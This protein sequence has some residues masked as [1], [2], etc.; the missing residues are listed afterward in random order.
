MSQETLSL[1]LATWSVWV[2]TDDLNFV[3]F[4]AWF[5]TKSLDP[6]LCSLE[7]WFHFLVR[8]HATT[9]TIKWTSSFSPIWYPKLHHLLANEFCHTGIDATGYRSSTARSFCFPSHLNPITKFS[10]TP[11]WNLLHH[12][13]YCFFFAVVSTTN[14][15]TPR[16]IYRRNTLK[17]FFANAIHVEHLTQLQ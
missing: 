4:Y 7:P 9:E 5:F 1:F 17:K 3:L 6:V 10:I 16:E 12:Q 14:S 11:S 13:L 15:S 2:K 8:K